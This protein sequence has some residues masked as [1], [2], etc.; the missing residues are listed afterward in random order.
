MIFP[1]RF[2]RT[3]SSCRDH[4]KVTIIARP[5]MRSR[6]TKPKPGIRLSRLLFL[7]AHSTAEK[8]ERA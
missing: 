5:T 2:Q 8:R 4:E 6:G 3:P 7:P 1:T